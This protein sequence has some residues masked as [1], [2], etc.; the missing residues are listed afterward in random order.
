MKVTALM[1]DFKSGLNDS[2]LLDFYVD[3]SL[4]EPQKKRYIALLKEYLDKFGDEDVSILSVPGRSEIT[5]NHTDHQHGCV[6]ACSINLDIICVAAKADKTE[7]YSNGQLIAGVSAEDT[8]FDPSQKHTSA[9]LC[10]GV[11]NR[12][13]VN[14]FKIGNFHAVMRSNVRVG[15]GLSSSAAFEVMIGTIMSYLYNEGK[16]DKVEI[17]K[18][19]Q[20]AENQYFGKPCGLMDQCACALGG[21]AYIDFEDPSN[22][23]I[24][25]I[26]FK[27]NDYGYSLCIVNTGGSHSKLTGEYSAITE[28]MGQIAAFF[29]EKVLRNVSERQILNNLKLLRDNYGDRAVMR[30]LHMIRENERVMRQRD[31]LKEGNIEGFIKTI[32]ESGNSS[33]KYLQ[34]VYTN[35]DVAYQPLSLALMISEGFLGEDEAC[36]VHGG[37]FA[38]TIQ[39]FVK[40]E[41]VSEYKKLMDKVFGKDACIVLQVNN[42]GSDRVL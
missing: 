24:D 14:G 9:A 35:I 38:G 27:L 8:S 20:Y 41:N 10:R 13:E 11:M 2:V 26:G 6:L 25:Q 5:G 34:N 31:N 28:E 37:G 40:N 4:V 42:H 36:R 30:S 39:A 22:P 23:I 19:S 15:S 32:K 17:A 7:V 18:Y 16:V 3:K 21:V 1:N 29:N 12:L 33:F